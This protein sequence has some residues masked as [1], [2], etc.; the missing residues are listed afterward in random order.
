MTEQEKTQTPVCCGERPVGQAGK[1]LVLSCQLCPRSPTYWRR[2][3]EHQT[4]GDDDA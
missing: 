3:E 4:G 2:T 1:P